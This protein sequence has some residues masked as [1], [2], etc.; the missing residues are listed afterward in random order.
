VGGKGGA[1]TDDAGGVTGDVHAGIGDD[2]G[3]SDPP[4]K[5][6]PVSNRNELEDTTGVHDEVVLELVQGM[7]MLESNVNGD[8]LDG[9]AVALVLVNST[10]VAVETSEVETMLSSSPESLATRCKP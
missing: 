10:D 3:P 2:V 9:V 5:D 7:L 8:G 4:T 6:P 1:V